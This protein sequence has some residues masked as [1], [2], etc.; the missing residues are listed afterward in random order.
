MDER[1]RIILPGTGRRPVITQHL[2]EALTADIAGTTARYVTI[3]GPPGAFCE[4]LDLDQLADSHDDVG[5]AQRSYARMLRAIEHAPCPVI[6][7]VDGV[8]L[9]GGL[10]LMAAADLVIATPRATFG[11][12]ETL[13]GLIPAV[14]LPCIARRVGPARARLLALEGGSIDAEQAL[15]AGLVDEVAPDLEAACARRAKRLTRMDA[16]AQCEVKT[17]AAAMDT[18]GADDDALRRFAD[19]YETPATRRRIARLAAGEPP[20]LDENGE[21]DA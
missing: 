20:W 6:A 8:A 19:L 5:S 17:I 16:A 11:L 9:G 3:E 7:L 18:P 13:V 14:A 21:A 1:L 4:G 10:G 12:P 15:R 2:A